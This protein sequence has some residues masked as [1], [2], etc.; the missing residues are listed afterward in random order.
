MA[1][2]AKNVAD[3]ILKLATNLLLFTIFTWEMLIYLSKDRFT[4]DQ[5]DSVNKQKTVD[6]MLLM[7]VRYA[8]L[9]ETHAEETSVRFR[10]LTR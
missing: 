1:K 2:V 4:S 8:I 9:T 10:S 5:I 7:M 6:M 3:T